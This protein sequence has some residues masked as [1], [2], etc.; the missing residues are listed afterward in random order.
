MRKNLY[1]EKVSFKKKS[2]L[3]LICLFVFT[4]KLASANLFIDKG[5]D[6]AQ[7]ISA[8]EKLDTHPSIAAA[9]KHIKADKSLSLMAHVVANLSNTSGISFEAPNL[10]S[11]QNSTE[12]NLRLS[13]VLES[14]YKPPKA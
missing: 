2:I 3:C 12:Q 11:I 14:I 7:S 1:N 5:F 6:R 9:I 4:F 8:I 13:Q 10:K